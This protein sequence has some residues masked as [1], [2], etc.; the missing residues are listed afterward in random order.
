MSELARERCIA[1]ALAA[2]WELPSPALT[3]AVDALKRSLSNS[4]NGTA[5][6]LGVTGHAV[7]RVLVGLP[8]RPEELADIT[9][10][11]SVSG[12]L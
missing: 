2:G 3:A 11:L 10:A 4:H 8:G 12:F 6:V 5:K 1:G 7:R 9:A